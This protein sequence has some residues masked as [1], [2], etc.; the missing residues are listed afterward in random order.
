MSSI[1]ASTPAIASVPVAAGASRPVIPIGYLRAFVTALVVLH[2]ALLAY[3]PAY[4]QTTARATSGGFWEQWTSLGVWYSG[5]VWFVWVGPLRLRQ[6]DAILIAAR[7]HR[8]DPE[9]RDRDHRCAVAQLGDERGVAVDTDGATGG[10]SCW[11]AAGR[12]QQAAVGPNFSSA[13]HQA[14]NTERALVRQ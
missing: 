7:E 3:Y 9:G 10:L 13:R 14:L 11:L 8:R 5:P 6:L 2:H 4:L 1:T 12:G